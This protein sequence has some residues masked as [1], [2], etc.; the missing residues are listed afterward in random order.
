MGADDAGRDQRAGDLA[1]DHTD[2][3]LRLV[4]G[5]AD[6]VAHPAV[7]G[8]VPAHSEVAGLDVLDGADPVNGHHGRASDR[9]PRL[10]VDDR[11]RNTDLLGHLGD[12]REQVARHGGHVKRLLV[13]GI[14]DAI[15][16]TQ[17]EDVEILPRGFVG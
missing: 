6:V 14:R 5:R 11:G 8:D 12:L 4:E 17:V 7:D 13:R 2:V 16:A 3:V 1:I 10:D 9:A 15:A